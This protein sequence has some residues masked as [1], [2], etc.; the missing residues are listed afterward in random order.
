[1]KDEMA[2]I[3]ENFDLETEKVEDFETKH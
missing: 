1:M 2:N 3:I